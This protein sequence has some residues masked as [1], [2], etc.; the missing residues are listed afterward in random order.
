MLARILLQQWPVVTR[1]AHRTFV[2]RLIAVGLVM[3]VISPVTAPFTTFELS[4]FVKTDP[5]SG[6]VPL[7]GT[8][9]AETQVKVTPHLVTIAPAAESDSIAP[10]TLRDDWMD[11]AAHAARSLGELHAVL[12]L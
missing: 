11:V 10:T 9:L 4:D 8:Q 2:A 7:P 12:R 1:S 3:L 5:P 6:A